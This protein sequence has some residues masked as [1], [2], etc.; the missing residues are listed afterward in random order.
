MLP[1]DTSVRRLG[2]FAFL[3]AFCEALSFYAA[4]L[5][6]YE[7][8]G[9]ILSVSIVMTAV[10]VAETLGAVV[11][12]TFADRLDRK[13][14]AALGGLAGALLLGALVFG[15]DIV[16]LTAVMVLATIASS[17][18]RPVVGAALP[19]LVIEG[20]LS[21]ANGYVQALRNAALTLAPIVV[22]V[23]VGLVGA[24][25]IFGAAAGSMLLATAVLTLVRGDFSAQR[26][27]GSTVSDSPFEGLAFL[28]RDRVLLTVVVAGALSWFTAAYCMIADLPLAIDELGAG[29]TG[30]G[31]LVAA[32]GVGSTAGAILAPIAMRR[33][34]AP[35]AFALAMVLEGIVI[36]LVAGVP[37][38]AIA[39]LTFVV[40][41][42][43]GGIG[44]VADQIV[45]QERVPDEARGRVRATN[46]AVMAAAYAISLG[47]GGF[48]VDL[49]GPRGTYVLGGLGVLVAGVLATVALRGPARVGATV[50]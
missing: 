31:I 38:L 45:V 18:I 6:A 35:R 47:I 7:L 46:D 34:G 33:F 41:G 3:A 26:T 4:S 39:C 11:G 42:V 25:G 16:V 15:G 19:N 12:G 22:G 9:S 8:T 50:S 23:G 48:V 5:Y 21:Y 17:P 32:W 37:T 49:A 10:A 27:A 2:V 13:R 44:V 28:R 20:D 14:I 36:A 40:G 1:S 24:R 43:F 29:E 30:Y